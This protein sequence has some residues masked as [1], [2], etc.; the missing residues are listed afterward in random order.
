MY[1]AAVCVCIRETHT[2]THTH[3]LPAVCPDLSGE[4]QPVNL[5]LSVTVTHLLPQRVFQP[6]THTHT[7]QEIA[8]HFLIY[9]NAPQGTLQKATVSLL[10]VCVFWV[11]ECARAC[12]HVNRQI[13][14]KDKWASSKDGQESRQ[15]GQQAGCH[16]CVC[17]CLSPVRLDVHR[18]VNL[19]QLC[20]CA[21]MRALRTHSHMITHGSRR[22]NIPIPGQE[23]QWD[24]NTSVSGW[25]FFFFWFPPAL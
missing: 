23:T 1:F 4:K 20:G 8:V 14:C 5:S 10:C 18:H 11:C 25:F 12:A 21:C 6:L 15:E 9:T 13:W 3:V 2:H 16:G 17:M 24:G 19:T 7:L 22:C